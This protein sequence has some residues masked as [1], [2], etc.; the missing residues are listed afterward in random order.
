[1]ASLP[2][3][4]EKMPEPGQALKSVKVGITDV[5]ITAGNQSGI[6]VDTDRF[7]VSK[8]KDPNRLQVEWTCA[9]PSGFTVEFKDNKSPF[10]QSRF[11]RVDAGSLFSGPVRDDVQGD[12]HL[13][14]DERNRYPYSVT[15][16]NRVLDPDGQ[17]DP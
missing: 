6:G 15:I 12:D 17:V 11:S 10:T 2:Y 13:P 8:G 14:K 1:V 3:K 5:P 16:G 9:S 4:E 7:F